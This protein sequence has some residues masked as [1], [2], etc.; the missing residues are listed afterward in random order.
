P[1]QLNAAI[2]PGLSA[3]VMRL[4]A[5]SPAD[6]PASAAEVAQTLQALEK[7]LQSLDPR[8]TG[9]GAAWPARRHR[10]WL[11]ALT[12]MPVALCLVGSGYLGQLILRVTRPDGTVQEIPLEPGT[13]VEVVEKDKK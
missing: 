7:D 9:A 11:V 3:L 13:K 2:P 10:G 8:T 12:L 5:K 1:V 4:L 6:R